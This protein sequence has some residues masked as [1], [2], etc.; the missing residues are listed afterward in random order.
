MFVAISVIATSCIKHEVIPP[1]VPM[2]DLEAYFIGTIDGATIELT[3]NVLGYTNSS[4]KSKI[5]LPPPSFS[6]AVYYSKMASASIPTSIKVGLGSVIWDASSE[7]DPALAPFNN[8]MLSNANPNYSNG[9]AA[10]FEV[11]YRDGFGNEWTSKETG[12]GNQDVEFVDIVQESDSTGDYSMFTCNFN[13]YVYR[14]YDDGTGTI[15][16]DS[17]NIQDA[18][19]I[20]WFK[21]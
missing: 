13:C 16:T 9:G 6:K 3:E 1:P 14:S 8:F 5:I 15:V 20:G 21:R 19:Y 7:P 11:I 2:V 17:T 10:G 18:T 12:F 4:E